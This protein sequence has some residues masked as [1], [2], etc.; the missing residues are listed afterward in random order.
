M[1]SRGRW[2]LEEIAIALATSAGPAAFE[3]AGPPRRLPFN[4]SGPLVLYA[5]VKQLDP[6][7][8]SP[9]RVA[10][11]RVDDAVRSSRLLAPMATEVHRLL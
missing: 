6:A 10:Q 11:G 4:R 1:T 3:A 8:G 2:L 9:V 7:T 5:D